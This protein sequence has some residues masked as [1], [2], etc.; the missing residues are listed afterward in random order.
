M[1]INLNVVREIEG[2]DPRYLRQC[3][4]AN[5]H[6]SL[7]AHYYILLKKKLLEGF[8][9]AD[10]LVI[11]EPHPVRNQSIAAPRSSKPYPPLRKI[12]EGLQNF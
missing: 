7:T 6:N 10:Q 12:A 11:E 8:T 2:A 3:L 5:K 1:P 4:E 9:E